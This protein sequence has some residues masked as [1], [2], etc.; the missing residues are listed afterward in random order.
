MNKLPL[1]IL[2]DSY[3]AKNTSLYKEGTEFLYSYCESRGGRYDKTVMFGLQYFL[4]EYL[5]TPV[6]KEDVNYAQDFWAEH[7]GDETVFSRENWD[8]IVDNHGG[9]L[10]VS[11]KAV[12]EGSLVD[13]HN[14]LFTIENTD[15]KCSWITNWLETLLMKVYY[16]ITIATQ[17]FNLRKQILKHLEESGT[18]ESI[19]FKL[20]DFGYRGA[21]SEESAREGSA[22]HLLSFKGSDNVGGIFLTKKYYNSGMTGFSIIATEHANVCSYGKGNEEQFFSDYFDKFPKGMIAGVSDTY[23]IFD[24]VENVFCGTL[25]EKILSRDGVFVCRPDSGDPLEI[26]PWILDKFYNAFGGR[27]NEKGY[28]VIN[29]KVR[30]IQGDGMDANT[31]DELYSK[32]EGLG[33]SADNLTVGS[34]GGLLVKGI[35]RDVQKFAIKASAAR[36]NGE[37]TELKK[38]PITDSGKKSKGG[39]FKLI[40]ENETYITVP[41]TDVRKD[42]LVEVYRDGDL[43]VDYKFEDIREKLHNY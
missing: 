30:V 13:T 32:I 43:L 26:I 6:T 42:E 7:F 34:G 31:I 2:T 4:K 41:I 10:P 19:D 28:K 21:H 27:I 36:I 24:L 33:W 11:I 39:K 18:P 22:A 17:S 35:D 23:N 3:K 14:V 12:P 1:T 38:E 15:P 25:K 20:C 29:D 16:P 8:Y 5:L 9:K 40:K 37:W